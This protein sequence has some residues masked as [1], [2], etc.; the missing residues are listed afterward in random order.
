MS[1]ALVLCRCVVGG[2]LPVPFGVQWLEPA[3]IRLDGLRV[4][5]QS[6]HLQVTGQSDCKSQANQTIPSHRPIRLQVTGQSDHT[7][8]QANQTIP[9]NRPIRSHASQRPIRLNMHEAGRL[10]GWLP[11]DMPGALASSVA[12][13]AHSRLRADLDHILLAHSQLRADLDHS[14][15]APIKHCRTW[16]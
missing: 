16:P 7:K 13:L 9:S 10:R 15:L 4:T 11:P 3:A 2:I 1:Q 12:A 6:D 5:G 8:S 14:L